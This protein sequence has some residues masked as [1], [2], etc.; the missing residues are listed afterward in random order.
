ML[1]DRI[2]Q[3]IDFLGESPKSLEEKTGIDRAKW[4]N[5][6][7][8]TN[9]I[10]ATEEHIEAILKT[11]PEYAYWVATGK[12]IPEAGQISPEIEETRQKLKRA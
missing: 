4:S 3:L 5:I 9:P 7:R 12:T 10:R 6:K 1:K 2:I 8:K 11:W